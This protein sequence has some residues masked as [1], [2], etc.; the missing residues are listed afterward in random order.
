MRAILMA[1]LTGFQRLFDTRGRQFST[2][3]TCAG[4]LFATLLVLAGCDSTSNSPA[5][6]G[7]VAMPAAGSGNAANAGSG[8]AV[9]DTSGITTVGGKTSTNGASGKT[10]AAAGGKGGKGGTT[11]TGGKAG[12]SGKA[13]GGASGAAGVEQPC[14]KDV[15][16]KAGQDECT[17]PLKPEDDRL[18]V[19]TVEGQERQFYIYA[20]K[21]YNPCKPASL[22]MDIHGMSETAEVHTGEDGFVS[23]GFPPG[24]GS[25]WRR[26]IQGENAIIVTPQGIGNNWTTASDVTFINKAADT[27]EAIADVDKE[28]VYVTGIS[29]GGMMTVRTGC[30]NSARWRGMMPVAMVT[31][32]CAG[33][34]R[35]TPVI[36]FHA[37]GDQLTN[38]E[39][40]KS[41]I[42][43][44]ARLNNCKTGP[45][46]DPTR[47]YGGP[48]TV[49]DPVCFPEPVNAGAPEETNRYG[50]S[51]VEC[52]T[53]FPE[54][55]CITWSQCDEGVEVVFCTVS[56]DSQP[57]GGHILYH[58]DS[59]LQ[60]AT[61]GWRFLKKFWKK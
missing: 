40:D 19:I 49:K 32:A 22:I 2:L 60:L 7:T 36:S 39:A 45:T 27:V 25:G 33:L 50:Y 48:N 15:T 30:D 54:S 38:Y 9:S 17:A 46:P 20:P 47:V 23:L 6:G 58:N 55:N 37:V 52:K 11:K 31:Q 57:I 12:T 3:Q 59:A 53:S 44:I 34:S 51:I 35:P 28:K 8:G 61:V 21:S 41:G 13:A 26:A 43:N 10:T 16:K 14:T 56:A 1:A 24:Y 5:A 18:C 42:E 4:G 29:M